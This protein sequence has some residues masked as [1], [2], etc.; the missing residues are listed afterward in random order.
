MIQSLARLRACNLAAR[1]ALTHRDL[2]ANV[3]SFR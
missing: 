1:R 3:K 2:F